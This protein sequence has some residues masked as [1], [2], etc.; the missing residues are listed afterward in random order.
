MS[1]ILKNES[2]MRFVL[3]ELDEAAVGKHAAHLGLE[4]VPLL[5][6]VEVLEHREA[7]LEQVR[8]KG[9][10]LPIREV[11]EAGLPHERDGILEQLRIVEGENQAAVH[12]DVEAGQLVDDLRQVLFGAR[13]VVIP[14]GT[15]AAPRDG[16]IGLPSQPNERKPAVVLE[17]GCR[18]PVPAREA[19]RL[20]ER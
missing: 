13:V 10:G 14:G 2:K 6:A 8:A 12:P 7:A 4:V 15:P 16:E 11:P 9:F 18:S 19:A 3:V 17:I 5:R 20:P 1:W